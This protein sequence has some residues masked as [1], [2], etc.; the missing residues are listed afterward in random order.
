MASCFMPAV[1]LHAAG[2][3]EPIKRPVRNDIRRS[4]PTSADFKS[5]HLRGGGGEGGG[6]GVNPFKQLDSLSISQQNV[7]GVSCIIVL[8]FGSLEVCGI[9]QDRNLVP[10][11]LHRKLTHIS[12]GSMMLTCMCLFP[13][14]QSWT[15]R[16]GVCA[17][18]TFFMIGF[19]LA[20]YIPDED[21]AKL[22]PMVWLSQ[23]PDLSVRFPCTLRVGT[24]KHTRGSAM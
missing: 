20:A 7:F 24:N 22:H 15:G 5:M 21:L 12:V 16:L 4:L 18:L 3:A 14:G 1:A 13:R 8:V 17:F 2:F 23:L 19:A 6:G 10:K 11:A 9:L